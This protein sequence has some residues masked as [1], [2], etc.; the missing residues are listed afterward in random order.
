MNF[1]PFD[2]LAA[3]LSGTNLIEA[4]AGTGKTYTIA[5][6]Y[7]RLIVEKRL[8]IDQI[9]VVTFTK[10]ATE[11]LKQRIRSRLLEARQA[12]KDGYA[13]DDLL[14]GLVHRNNEPVMSRVRISDALRDFDACA[15]FTIHGF[16]RRILHENA[17]ETGSLFDTE[18]VTDQKNLLTS[19]SDDFWRHMLYGASPE[20]IGY[21]LSALKGPAG[22]IKLLEKSKDLNLRVIPEQ[23]RPQL[24]SIE[25]FRAA[26]RVIEKAWPDARGTVQ[27]L[28]MDPGLYA[29]V[30]GSLKTEK[31]QSG[32]T[33]RHATVKKLLTAMDRFSA[34]RALRFPLSKE[35]KKLTAATLRNKTKKGLPPPEHSFF[36]QCDDLD[37]AG[38]RLLLEM[39]DLLLFFK[40]DL[41]R[42]VR[43]QLAR[44]KKS[45]NV[46]Y[47]DDLLI[48]VR[49][50]LMQP[51]AGLL[52]AAVRRRYQAALV[53]E[54]QD[55]DMLQYSI[56]SRLFSGDNNSLLFMIGDPKQAIYGFRG[57]D[58]FSYM[59]AS[60]CSENR[61]T[62]LTNYRSHPHLITAVNTL[63]SRVKKPFVFSEIPFV[64][65]LP[66]RHRKTRTTDSRE[67]FQLWFAGSKERRPLGKNDAVHAIAAAVSAEISRLVS[68]PDGM[69]PGDIAVLVRTHRQAGIIKQQLSSNRVPAVVY[70]AGNVFQTAEARDLFLLLASISEPFNEGRFRAALATRILDAPLQDLD[71]GCKAAD[72]WEPALRRF[73]RYH[74]AWLAH[75]F[76]G[77]FNDLLSEEKVRARLLGLTDGERRLTNLLHLAE[78]LHTC[79]VQKNLGMQGLLKWFSI[80]RDP[81]SDMPETHQLRLESDAHTVKIITIHKSKGLEFPVV[82]CPF[83]WDAS[84]VKGAD[85][86]FHDPGAAQRLT[87]DLGSPGIEEHRELA[88]YELLAENLRL[89]YVALTRARD[90]C[91]LVWGRI[92]DVESS[93]LAYLLHYHANESE[94]A[95]EEGLF[96]EIQ[97]QF[98]SKDNKTLVRDIKTLETASGGNIYVTDITDMPSHDLAA[99]AKPPNSLPASNRQPLTVRKFSASIDR[100]WRISSFSSLISGRTPENDQMENDQMENAQMENDQMDSEQPD[101]DGP[102]HAVPPEELRTEINAAGGDHTIFSFPRGTGPGIFFHDIFENIDFCAVGSSAQKKTIF[103]KMRV[104]GYDPVWQDAVLKTIERVLTVPLHGETDRFSLGAVSREQRINEMEFY[105]PLRKIS[106]ENIRHVFDRHG[107]RARV[108]EFPDP[109]GRLQFAPAKGFMKGFIDLVFE[110]NGKYYLVDWKSNHLGPTIDDYRPELL[111]NTMQGSLYVLQYH[112]YTLALHLYLKIRL[113]GYRYEKDF[114]GV[115]YIFIRGV[116]PAAGPDYGVF[117]DCPD[118]ELV[119]ALER[120]LLPYV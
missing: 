70:N 37:A 88:Q 89:L 112:I 25:P 93:A 92:K 97:F 53:D 43:E 34:G 48:Q 44:K 75:G 27:Q 109:V 67:V 90:K 62:L 78:L 116:D 104:Y 94:S 115:F 33:V 60:S 98:R 23:A 58:I 101:R 105:F 16:C 6:L 5:G 83:A 74:Q 29:N 4:S 87:L 61:Y 119:A 20:F 59:Q 22:L 2:I 1:K 86:A 71:L 65:G 36:N 96:Q 95:P 24:N 50:A 52:A 63:F 39:R 18:L 80:Q 69:H 99:G 79:A 82:F 38:E 64:K 66:D 54:F 26:C 56:F 8:R 111:E 108:P 31:Q 77:M 32:Q 45:M 114:G 76:M 21:T 11:E 85:F 40:A 35:F 120:N 106:A 113:P 73:V 51:G 118:K 42:F 117:F 72:W 47:F 12:F 14:D 55:T 10:A 91:Y 102:V 28:L 68:G 7:L 9:L 81:R 57:A 103:E 107:L 19:I 84:T 100:T 3:P 15:I 110:F 46:Q 49:D 30:Y 41:F 13:G 17:F